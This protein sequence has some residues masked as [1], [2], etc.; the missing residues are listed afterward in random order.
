VQL[1]DVDPLSIANELAALATLRKACQEVYDRF[2]AGETVEVGVVASLGPCCV[3][4]RGIRPGARRLNC[5]CRL[6]LR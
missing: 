6:R 3:M 2:P 4:S 5:V 1:V